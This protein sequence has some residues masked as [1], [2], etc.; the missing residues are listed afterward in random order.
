MVS[1]MV[2]LFSEKVLIF[3]RCTH[4][5]MSNYVKKSGKDSNG[6]AL[7]TLSA[8]E[9]GVLQNQVHFIL[10]FFKLDSTFC[11]YFSPFA[12]NK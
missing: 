6:H 1:L 11:F 7:V 4:V 10:D 5:F 9:I 12:S 8:N 3:T 2:T